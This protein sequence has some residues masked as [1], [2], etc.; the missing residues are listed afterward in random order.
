MFV[1][2]QSCTTKLGI[3]NEDEHGEPVYNFIGGFN[4][5][6]AYSV[7]GFRPMVEISF[8][9][10]EI[11]VQPGCAPSLLVQAQSVAAQKLGAVG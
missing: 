3:Y 9:P 4:S 1:S 6:T 11:G 5:M 2:T 7:M 10:E 8:M